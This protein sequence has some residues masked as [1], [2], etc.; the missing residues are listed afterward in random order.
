MP[1]IS[2]AIGTDVTKKDTHQ[3]V[4]Q[5]ARLHGRMVF[6]TAYRILGNAQGAEDVQQD[7]FLKLLRKSPSNESVN[8]WPALLRV[9]AQNRALDVLRRESKKRHIELD[10]DI[11]GIDGHPD[12]D[13]LQHQRARQLRDALTRLSSKDATLFGLRFIENLSYEQIANQLGGTANKVGVQIHRIKQ[14]ISDFIQQAQK[15]TDHDI[16]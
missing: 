1:F 15:G 14:R 9:M 5:L 13:L 11:E 10:P 2:R 3:Q 4:T 16:H 12:E 7:V 8:N 6:A